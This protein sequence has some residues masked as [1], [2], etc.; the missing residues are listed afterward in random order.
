[1]GGK[2]T[3]DRDPD[4][5]SWYAADITQELID[6]VTAPDPAKL[7][8]DLVGVEELQGPA[9]QTVEVAGVTRTYVVVLL[10]P[11]DGAVP[12]DWRW[13]ARVSCLNGERFDKTTWF[14]KVDT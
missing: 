10:G 13:T 1:V 3:V 8:L 4:E 7:T 9:L 6:R 5:I 11:I 14:R 12:G 2:M